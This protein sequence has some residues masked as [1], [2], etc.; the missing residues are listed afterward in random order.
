MKNKCILQVFLSGL[1][2]CGISMAQTFHSHP[3]RIAGS[4][5][6]LVTG[7][8]DSNVMVAVYTDSAQTNHCAVIDG[9]TITELV[10][11][12]EVGTG[13][14]AG[15]SCYGINNAG[16]VIGTYSAAA[17]G[18]GFIY[19]GGTYTDIVFPGATAGTS[20][21]GLNNVGQVVGSYADNTGQFGFLYTIS[22][23]TFTKLSVPGAYASLAVGINDGGEISFEWVNPTFIFSGALLKNN[24][25]R[26]LNVPGMSQSKARGINVHGEIVVNG[27]DASGVWHGFL[28]KGGAYTQFDVA[29][30]ANTYCFGINSSAEL[31]GGYNPTAHPTNQVGFEGRFSAASN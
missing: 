13:P 23:N 28:Y 26:I 3:V 4:T 9:S 31:V 11:P 7:I 24:H 21:Y 18:N 1:A 29:N 10:D 27:Q 2:L 5:N 6:V 19:S 16:E 12:N 25:Y 14:G 22:T 8:N 20:A 30:A 15:T 17:F